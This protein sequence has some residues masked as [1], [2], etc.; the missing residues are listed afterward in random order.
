MKPLPPAPLTEED[1]PIW[2][3]VCVWYWHKRHGFCAEHAARNADRRDAALMFA[4]AKGWPID[5]GGDDDEGECLFWGD[6][7]VVPP[8]ES[9]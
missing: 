9:L 2:R 1:I 6:P 7:P 3:L 8:P 4:W 5:L